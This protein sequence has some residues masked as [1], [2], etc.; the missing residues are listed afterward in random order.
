MVDVEAGR[1][2][3]A[4]WPG[5]SGSPL[6]LTADGLV[7]Y[8]GLPT[9]GAPPEF[10]RVYSSAVGPRTM[11]TLKVAD[12]SSQRFETILPSVDPRRNVSFGSP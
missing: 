9:E 8:W 3:P 6:A 2:E 12:L 10:T 11:K 7:L 1:S 4:R 5:D